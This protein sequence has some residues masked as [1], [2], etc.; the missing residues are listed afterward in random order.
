MRR[1]LEVSNIA[2]VGDDL[3]LP[4]GP[5]LQAPIVVIL[6]IGTTPSK[7]CCP[8]IGCGSAMQRSSCSPPA[9]GAA[10]VPSFY[11]MDAAVAPALM[12]ELFTSVVE[13]VGDC[14]T[15]TSCPMYSNAYWTLLVLSDVT[16][17]ILHTSSNI[18]S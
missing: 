3:I 4:R 18:N 12:A 15:C 17:A 10:L 16:G 6:D 2:A 8:S 1:L 13:T 11:A 14:S 7:A 9:G 5:D